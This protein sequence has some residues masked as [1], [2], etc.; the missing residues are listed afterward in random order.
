MKTG[1]KIGLIAAVAVLLLAGIGLSY[2]WFAQHAA[3]STLLNIIP[4]DS[5]TIIPI[6][7]KTGAGMI[8]LDLDFQDGVDTKDADGTIHIR[9]PICIESTSPVYQLEVVRTTNLSKLTFNI[10]PAVKNEDG[11]L[12]YDT[13]NALSGAYRNQRNGDPSLAKAETLDNYKG[14]D[15]VEDHAYPLYW[16]ATESGC[17]AFV[18]SGWNN[19]WKDVESHSETRFDPAKQVN[20]TYYSTYYYLEI[21]WQEETKE[22]DLFYILAKNVAVN[23]E[24]N[25][26]N[27]GSVSAQ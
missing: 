20:K 3:M 26:S 14:T 8:G 18:A 23:V 1:R 11:S 7:S 9:R 13:N 24:E 21:S 10:Y 25:T 15:A 4:P 22:T 27:E 6:D 2:A 12:S 17:K 19:N 5:I 16:L